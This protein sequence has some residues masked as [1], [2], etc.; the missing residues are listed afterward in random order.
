MWA[1]YLQGYVVVHVVQHQICRFCTGRWCCRTTNAT[2]QDNKFG[3]CVREEE[4]I[5]PVPKIGEEETERVVAT[6]A[7]TND[8]ER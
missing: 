1:G 3:I 2:L 7:K 4:K 8:K 6:V 5:S